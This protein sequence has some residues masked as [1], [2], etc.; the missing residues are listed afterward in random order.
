VRALATF[1]THPAVRL[2]AESDPLPCKENP[3]DRLV[4]TV[5]GY[6]WQHTRQVVD[7]ATEEKR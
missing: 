7:T 3:A 2:L 4:A 6:P 5:P 1:D